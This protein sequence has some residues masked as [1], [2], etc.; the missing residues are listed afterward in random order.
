MNYVGESWVKKAREWE[1]RFAS[2]SGEARVLFVSI[3]PVPAPKGECS[4]F[5]IALGV[6]RILDEDAGHAII[7]K[8]MAEE[9][10]RG[11]V[12]RSQ[13]FRG[14]RCPEIKT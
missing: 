10:S 7:K 12:V 9:I 4:E 6:S 13:V 14:I 2:V 5:K 11:L 1:S 8:V 3:S